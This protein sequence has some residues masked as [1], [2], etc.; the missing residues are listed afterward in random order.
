MHLHYNFVSQR[1]MMEK[2]SAWVVLFGKQPEVRLWGQ[3]L[4]GNIVH[5]FS[6]NISAPIQHCTH[7]G[8]YVPVG[9]TQTCDW[10]REAWV[11]GTAGASFEMRTK[12]DE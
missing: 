10:D 8:V 9:D 4:E 6:D 3:W 5:D 11:T 2:Y 7:N 12:R 1:D